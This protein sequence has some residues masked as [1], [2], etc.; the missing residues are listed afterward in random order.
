MVVNMGDDEAKSGYAQAIAGLSSR[1]RD[2][3]CLGIHGP[4]GLDSFR[5]L[6]ASRKGTHSSHPM[7]YARPV[8][9]VQGC[10]SW[11]RD[12]PQSAPGWE[13]HTSCRALTPSDQIGWPD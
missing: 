5:T 11:I 12:E 8:E 9:F 4:L 2:R 3:L 7:V 10:S 13:C 1:L 6:A